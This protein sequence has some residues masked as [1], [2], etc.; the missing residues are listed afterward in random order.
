MVQLGAVVGQS[1]RFCRYGARAARPVI[2]VWVDGVEGWVDG[3][4]REVR[5]GEGDQEDQEDRGAL[6]RR[7]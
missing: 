1:I 7:C 5:G 4:N 6:V 2:G 3:G